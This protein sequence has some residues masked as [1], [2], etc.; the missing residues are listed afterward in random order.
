[1]T[2]QRKGADAC[3]PSLQKTVLFSGHT[4]VA[5]KNDTTYSRGLDT[6]HKGM[7]HDCC[8]VTTGSV[9]TTTQHTVGYA[10]N[11]PAKGKVPAKRVPCTVTAVS[12][13]RAKMAYWEG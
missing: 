6:I 9:Y 2:G 4:Y 8:H 12:T 1:M 10:V 13:V 3:S 7:P 11:K 5:L